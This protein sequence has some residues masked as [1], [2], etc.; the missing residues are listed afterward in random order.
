M[1]KTQVPKHTEKITHDLSWGDPR[2]K[3]HL[4]KTEMKSFYED[5]SRDL[6]SSLI[7]QKA[8]KLLLW[9]LG[10]NP[11]FDAEISVQFY[12]FIWINC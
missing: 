11:F 10:K 7:Q 8:T 3:N 4:N 12:I 1:L 2:R 6:V 5:A 9:I